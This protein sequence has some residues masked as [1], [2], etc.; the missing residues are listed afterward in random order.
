MT[1]F[2]DMVKELKS[3]ITGELKDQLSINMA[4]KPMDMKE[5][6]CAPGIG[7]FFSKAKCYVLQV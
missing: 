5:K 2:K 7:V 4:L 6:G 1:K 3:A